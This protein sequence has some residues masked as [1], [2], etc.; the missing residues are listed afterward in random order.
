[1]NYF[2]SEDDFIIYVDQ[3]HMILNYLKHLQDIS[4]V[5]PEIQ[6]HDTDF[7][8]L[9]PLSCLQVTELQAYCSQRKGLIFDG[10]SDVWVKNTRRFEL[11]S[12]MCN[13]SSINQLCHSFDVRLLSTEQSIA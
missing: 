5:G 11:L 4:G 3:N 13:Q 9:V 8:T 2:L 10:F 7:P 6:V 1:M 12:D